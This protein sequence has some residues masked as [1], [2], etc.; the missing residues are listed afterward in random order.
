MAPRKATAAASGDP[1]RRSTRISGQPAAAPAEDTALKATAASASKK[2]VAEDVAES[3][4]DAD[5]SNKKA[6][7]EESAED[8]DK[9]AD[10]KLA[11]VNIGD[12]LPSVT[13]KN[14]KG[15]DVAI[16]EIAKEKGVVMFLVPRADTPGCTTQACGFRDI[17][18]EFTSLN[19]DVYCLSADASV[20]QTKWQTKKELPYG[21]LS[22][23]KRILVTALG[24]GEGGK[25]KRS[26][27]IFEKGG[28]LLDKKMPV[29][30]ADSPKLALEFIKNYSS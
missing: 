24:A 28:K 22:D 20:A 2:R 4:T 8:N 19:Y 25:T 3:P 6:K 30:P 13:L 17:Y 21:L 9:A 16:G 23:P 12:I 27:F 1:P 5:S 11:P 15:E 10:V 26:H 14:E 7:P 18:S 29:K